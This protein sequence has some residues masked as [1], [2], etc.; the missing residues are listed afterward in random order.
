MADVKVNGEYLSR[1]IYFERKPAGIGNNW[2]T[3]LV[4]RDGQG[5]A[6]VVRGGPNTSQNL[7]DFFD[8]FSFLSLL[9]CL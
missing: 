1:G 2:H 4:Y 5:G 9:F 3:Y 6:W 8:I 7:S